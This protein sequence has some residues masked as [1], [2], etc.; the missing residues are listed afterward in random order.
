VAYS[1]R[2][3]MKTAAMGLGGLFASERNLVAQPVNHSCALADPR[4]EIEITGL[5]IIPV[6]SLRSIFV[7]MQTDAGITGIGEGKTRREKPTQVGHQSTTCRSHWSN[8]A[9]CADTNQSL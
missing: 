1:R 5:E 7:K 3:W 4:D 9:C 6:N 2:T 8:E